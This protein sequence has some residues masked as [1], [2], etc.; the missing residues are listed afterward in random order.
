MLR[1]RSATSKMLSR[2]SA[3]RGTRGRFKCFSTGA[4]GRKDPARAPGG[5]LE[6]SGLRPLQECT[7]AHTTHGP[8]NGPAGPCRIRENAQHLMTYYAAAS[9]EMAINESLA[10]VALGAGDRED[11]TVGPSPAIRGETGSRAEL[12]AA[13]GQHHRFVPSARQ[14][15]PSLGRPSEDSA[16]HGCHWSAPERASVKR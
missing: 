11:G 12:G 16:N 2:H 3:R 10:T 13:Q 6:G 9:A 5:S 15:R 7:C 14:L 8:H 4:R 1:L